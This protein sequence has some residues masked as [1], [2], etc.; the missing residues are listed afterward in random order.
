[1]VRK[2]NSLFR[3][4]SNHVGRVCTRSEVL[5]TLPTE[6][7]HEVVKKQIRHMYIRRSGRCMKCG[8]P[9][10]GVEGATVHGL[11][12][13][14]QLLLASRLKKCDKVSQEANVRMIL[15]SRHVC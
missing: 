11:R 8:I 15:V 10:Y 1:M 4:I 12:M 7:R 13:G 3:G 6:F 14:Q 9:G 2:N 5:S